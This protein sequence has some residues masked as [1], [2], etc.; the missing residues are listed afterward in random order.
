MKITL[1]RHAEVEERYI[2]CFNGHI[3]IEL[4]N[5]GKKEAKILAH[6]YANDEFDAVFCSDLKRAKQT[7]KYFSHAKDAVYT[8]KLREKS[9]GEHEGKKFEELGIKYENFGQFI[10]SLD[11]ERFDDFTSRIKEFFYDYLPT[12]QK[13]NVLIITHAG[14]IRT[15]LC[16]YQN[17][18]IEKA[19]SID[20]PYGSITKIK[21]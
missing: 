6:T 2:G 17:I 7:L 8:E 18:T 20:I 15:L 21:I 1:I 3:D 19:F 13:E 10:N 12:L 9:L 5:K 4:S 14:V 16:F 11:G